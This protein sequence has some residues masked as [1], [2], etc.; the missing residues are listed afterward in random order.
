VKELAQGSGLRQQ[1]SG[2][3]SPEKYVRLKPNYE[4]PESYATCSGEQ[5]LWTNSLRALLS[6]EKFLDRS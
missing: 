1:A 2:L 4:I 3:R 5:R 6:R